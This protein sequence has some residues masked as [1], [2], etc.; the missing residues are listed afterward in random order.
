MVGLGAGLAKRGLYHSLRGWG[1][2]QGSPSLRGSASRHPT[3]RDPPPGYFGAFPPPQ[4]RA[5]QPHSRVLGRW[6]DGAGPCMTVGLGSPQERPKSAVFAN[7]TKV[8]M[9]VEEQIDRMKRHQSGSMKEKRRSLQLPSSHQPET[10]GTKAPASYK[11]VSPRTGHGAGANRPVF[12]R[13]PKVPDGAEG[14]L[15]AGEGGGCWGRGLCHPGGTQRG[16]GPSQVRRHRSIH[17][18]D[19]SDLEAALRS[20]DPGKVYETPQEEIARLRK[21]ELE[22]QHYDVDIN[23]EVRTGRRGRLG[24]GHPSLRALHRGVHPSSCIGQDPGATGRTRPEVAL[25]QA[26]AGGEWGRWVLECGW[27]PG[28]Q[29]TAQPFPLPP[30]LHAG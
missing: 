13:V 15:G 23:K 9:S 1:S 21:M 26:G 5:E 20:D 29:H 4:E 28:G 14:T 8:K 27:V 30:A 25:A 10:P 12:C 2:A 24:T 3:P 22:P 18:V 7:E 6:E 11:V 17:E 16:W 19:I